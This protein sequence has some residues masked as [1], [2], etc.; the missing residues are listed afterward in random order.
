ML[1]LTREVVRQEHW[2]REIPALD[3]ADLHVDE[4]CE[5]V[6]P[7]GAPLLTY[8]PLGIDLDDVREALPHIK[9]FQPRDRTGGM[10]TRSTTF[11][12]NPRIPMRRDYCNIT[13][14]TREYPRMYDRLIELAII[15]AAEYR[16]ANP[17]E[18]EQHMALVQR[19]VLPEWVMPGTPFT[20]G[21][22]NDTTALPY[23][24]DRGNFPGSWSAMITVRDP[25]VDGGWLI[26]PELGVALRT[27]HAS[28][29]LFQGERWWHGVSPL[30]LT[31]RK[32]RRY[33]LVFYSLQAICKCE[34]LAAEIERYKVVRTT[35]ERNRYEGVK[36]PTEERP[37]SVRPLA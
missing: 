33:T 24:R 12:T 22:I 21:I 23:H 3:H 20:G 6:A 9:T 5:I 37:R 2:G 13:R 35:R 18:Y 29:L 25:G 17:A 26:V 28:I 1:R 27:A 34:T 4:A 30:G 16:V 14:L 8:R 19:G 31:K 15:A 10:V 36:A 32:A 11:G 7:N